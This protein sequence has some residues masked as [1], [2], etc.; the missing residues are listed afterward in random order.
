M[1]YWKIFVFTLVV[2][3]SCL[4]ETS[5]GQDQVYGVYTVLGGNRTELVVQT[6]LFDLVNGNV[7]TLVTNF[8]YV[9]DK[10]TVDG[11][12]TFDQKHGIFHYSTDT[13][14]IW[15]VDVTTNQITA[16][17][18]FDSKDIND[19]KYNPNDNNL[20]ILFDDEFGS[21]FYASYS[22][23]NGPAIIVAN[24]T[25]YL[26]TAGY[27]ETAAI[28]INNQSPTPSNYYFVTSYFYETQSINVYHADTMTFSNATIQGDCGNSNLSFSYLQYNSSN[29]D[30]VWGIQSGLLDGKFYY[31]FS[32]VY[33][34]S[35][36]CV[37]TET[38][39]GNGIV[40]ALTYSPDSQ[41]L[42]YASSLGGPPQICYTSVGFLTVPFLYGELTC[43][44]V[45]TDITDLEVSYPIR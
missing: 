21:T 36:K 15:G 33:V 14:F 44:D 45:L 3:L 40:T 27:F 39:W 1:F 35:G 30:Y 18:N 29:P 20:Y 26:D 23:V 25:S 5:L 8:V 19:L 6:G 22:T 28:S 41:T 34:E 2:L 24:L 7:T 32:V 17:I 12:S 42:Y 16:P 9:G 38:N 10:S 11:V 13:A 43:V 31:Y 37:I 4:L